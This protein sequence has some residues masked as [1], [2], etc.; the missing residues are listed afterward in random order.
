[1][2]QGRRPLK[3]YAIYLAATI[4]LSVLGAYLGRAYIQAPP[5]GFC[6]QRSLAL[7]DAEFIQTAIQLREVDWKQRGGKQ[8][9]VYS[10]KDF[11]PR[12]PNCCRVI[13]DKSYSLVNRMFDQ[14]EIAV[15][16]NN[17]T[18]T[19]AIEGANLN[20]RFFFDV[21]GNLKGRIEYDWQGM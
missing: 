13:R 16:L 14:Q 21:C 10:G 7:S 18:S 20:D 17:E 5:A 11:D 9:F 8:K 1:M 12:N 19:Q 4:A 6:Q 3:R 2:N 15:E